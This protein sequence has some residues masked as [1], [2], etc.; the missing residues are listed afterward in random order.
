MHATC[1]SVDGALKYN[2]STL[3]NPPG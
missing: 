2:T 3:P 1:I